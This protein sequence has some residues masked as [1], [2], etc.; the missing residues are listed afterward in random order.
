MTNQPINPGDAPAARCWICRERNAV[1]SAPPDPARASAPVCAPCHE[2]L[3]S[4]DAAWRRLEVHL[5]THWSAITAR[6]SF[7]LTKLPADDTAGQALD[8]HLFFVQRLADRLQGERI[9]VDLASFAVALRER[10]AHPEVVLL[11]AD[12]RTRSGTLL[13]HASDV[14]VLRSGDEVHSALW[15]HLAHPLA[16]KVCYLKSGAPVQP[17]DGYPWHPT[18]Q[19]KI[20]K[21]SPLKGDAQPLVARR[22]LR[23]LTVR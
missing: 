10:V 20:V 23:I 7:D 18:R 13:L 11:V 9:S 12:A 2:R 14:S 5:R 6:G 3:Q 19:R 8:I 21:L 1:A 4:Y 22:D 16:V 17:P 15:S